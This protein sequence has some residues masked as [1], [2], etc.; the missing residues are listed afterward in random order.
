MRKPLLASTAVLLASACFGCSWAA[1]GESADACTERVGRTVRGVLGGAGGVAL[2]CTQI[3][4]PAQLVELY[5][6]SDAAGPCIVVTGMPGGPR[7]CGRAPGEREPAVERAI[8]AGPI[9]RRSSRSPFEVY[10]ETRADVGQ[11]VLRYTLPRGGRGTSRATLV[12]A[13]DAGALAAAGIREPFGYFV[14]QVPGDAQ[15]VVAEA[16][17]RS[18][19]RLGAADFSGVMRS[20]HP[21]VFIAEER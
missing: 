8:S 11:V 16:S 4:G 5:A 13:A 14:G 21:T 12:E 18:G 6:V 2:G 1:S 7:A 3:R 15:D 9:V 19:R 17:E 10:G 20:M